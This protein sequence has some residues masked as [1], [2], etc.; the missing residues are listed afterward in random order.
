MR[1]LAGTGGLVRLIL[2][3]DRILLPVWLLG[4]VGLFLSW[5]ASIER[6]YPTEAD[7]R[8]VAEQVMGTP[9]F[10]LFQG[11]IFE[12]SVGGMVAQRGLVQAGILAALGAA[13]FVV[14]HTRREEETGR[15][16]LLGSAVVGRHAPLTAALAVVMGAGVLAALVSVVGLVG[17]GLPVVGSVASG[18]VVGSAVWVSAALAAVLAQVSESARSAGLGAAVLYFGFHL[19]SGVAVIGD[20]LAWLGWLV[21]NGWLAQLRPYTGERWWV[22]ALI[23][24]W[25]ILLT[26]AAYAVSARRDLGSALRTVQPGPAAA[27]EGLRS[28]LGLAW[29]LHRGALAAWTVGIAGTGLTLGYVGGDAMEEYARASWV[30]EFAATI[31]ADSAGDAFLFYLAFVMVFLIAAYAI[32]TMLRMRSEE[33]DGY[34]ETI[35]ST[36]HSRTGWAAGHLVFGLAG[37][38]VLFLVLGLALGFGSAAAGG[39]LAGVA[40][41]LGLTLS[42]TPA[43]WVVVGATMLAFG[44]LPRACALLAWAVL[45]VGIVAEIGVKIAVL[46]EWVFLAVSPYAHVNPY[47]APGAD[48]YLALTVLAAALV[49]VGLIALRRRDLVPNG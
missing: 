24:A 29:R 11:P 5:A 8:E 10:V 14:R 22:L 33:A 27:A 36:A 17:M 15:R 2:R 20:G 44:L 31:G 26:G 30:L 47:Y 6:L 32:T 35:L 45:G 25:V 40:Q 46:P 13:L 1:E 34:A 4:I 7:L 21:P 38:V 42:L 28:P 12:P 3:R 39:D 23:A 49:G 43:V 16:E 48:S 37:P 18:V 19:V 9:M 41:M